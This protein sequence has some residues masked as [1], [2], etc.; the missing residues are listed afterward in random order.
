MRPP[1]RLGL[2]CS[3]CRRPRLDSYGALGAD[4]EGT[5]PRTLEEGEARAQRAKKKL[6][7]ARRATLSSAGKKIMPRL[8]N[9]HE[10]ISFKSLSKLKLLS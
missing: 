6:C 5:R 7:P 4:E 1:S 3:G 8:Q 2:V 10:A 9:K